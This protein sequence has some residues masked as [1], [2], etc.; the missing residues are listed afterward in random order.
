MTADE[1]ARS[2]PL[3]PKN[4][5][6]KD[7]QR[8]SL[9]VS[10]WVSECA[11]K[12]AVAE[13]TQEETNSVF[14]NWIKRGRYTDLIMFYMVKKLIRTPRPK[15]NLEATQE[16]RARQV[17][18]AAAKLHGKIAVIT[19]G[20]IVEKGQEAGDTKASLAE[21]WTKFGQKPRSVITEMMEDITRELLLTKEEETPTAEA[22]E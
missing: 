2:L 19:G 17:L 10:T 1:V 21:T 13:L 4:I 8:V 9:L 5:A 3:P 22:A 20:K 15:R 14:W 6:G 18:N 11:G 7:G 16:T 12:C